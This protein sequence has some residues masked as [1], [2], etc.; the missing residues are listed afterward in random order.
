MRQRVDGPM[1]LGEP[2]ATLIA[3]NSLPVRDQLGKQ[4]RAAGVEFF[5]VTAAINA[6]PAGHRRSKFV[7]REDHRVAGIGDAFNLPV[8]KR[9][10]GTL[11]VLIDLVGL[12]AGL[13]GIRARRP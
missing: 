7:S 6:L 5:S 3:G 8:L 10:R 1:A 11:T 2:A 13:A 4:F 12:P 9:V